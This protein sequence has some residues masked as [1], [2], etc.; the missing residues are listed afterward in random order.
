MTRAE[1]RRASRIAKKQAKERPVLTVHMGNYPIMVM[2]GGVPICA[3]CVDFESD[4]CPSELPTW[5]CLRWF[6]VLAVTEERIRV[7]RSRQT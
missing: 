1:R 2:G 4:R 3:S 6:G 5:C 7:V